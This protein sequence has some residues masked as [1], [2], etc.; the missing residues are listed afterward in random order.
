MRKR[1][2]EEASEDIGCCS[3]V[4]FF[5]CLFLL[6]VGQSTQRRSFNLLVRREG[7]SGH[8]P[9]HPP[10]NCKASPSP[11]KQNPSA[12]ILFF[13]RR[14]PT[15][16]ENSLAFI[17]RAMAPI[18]WRSIDFLAAKNETLRPHS[19][20]STNGSTNYASRFGREKGIFFSSF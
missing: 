20:M 10:C 4:D 3:F 7:G 11:H 2:R 12:T 18:H 13:S 14:C 5:C 1:G 8:P 17:D 15:R 9:L 19:R 6:F 16:N